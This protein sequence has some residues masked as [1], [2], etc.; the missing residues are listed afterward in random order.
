MG[1]VFSWVRQLG[2]AG[3]V[4][5]A[6]IASVVGISLLL[7]FILA[8][9]AYRRRYFRRRDA[10]TFAIRK[11]RKSTRLNSSH[12]QKSRMPSSA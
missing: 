6:I 12:I 9:R 1:S 8:R 2:P 11:D 7:A 10:R 4:L 3:F 5:K